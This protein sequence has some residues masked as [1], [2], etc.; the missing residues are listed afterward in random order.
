MTD[1]SDLIR[2]EDYPVPGDEEL[3]EKSTMS[4][5]WEIPNVLTPMNTPT[6][7]IRAFM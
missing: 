5:S 3:K 1:L 2:A 7:S 4:P 6:Y